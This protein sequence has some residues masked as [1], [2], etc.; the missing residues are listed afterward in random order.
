MVLHSRHPA[1]SAP[2]SLVQTPVLPRCNFI[3]R[4]LSVGVLSKRDFSLHRLTASTAWAPGLSENMGPRIAAEMESAPA[5]F[6]R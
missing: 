3:F 5:I 4:P 1:A 2:S 6:I